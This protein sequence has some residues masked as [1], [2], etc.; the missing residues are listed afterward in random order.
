L[1]DLNNSVIPEKNNNLI[2]LPYDELL[3]TQEDQDTIEDCLNGI[4]RD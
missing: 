3:Y 4:D 2:D 1:T